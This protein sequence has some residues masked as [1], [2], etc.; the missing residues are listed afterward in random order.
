MISL[1][2][3][4]LWT[5]SAVLALFAVVT[6]AGLL[7]ANRERS[8]QAQQERMRGL[9]YTLL[10]AANLAPDGS[11]ELAGELLAE[12]GFRQPDSGL[13]GMVTA[14]GGRVLWV[15][16]SLLDPPPA[17]AVPAVDEWRF[18]AA[19]SADD[20]FVLSYGVR[21]L[22]EDDSVQRFG[23]VVTE[24]AAPHFAANAAFVRQLWLWLAIPMVGLLL[25]QVAVLN[26]ALRPLRR[27]EEELAELETGRETRLGDAYP[28][29]LQPLKEALN[30]LLAAEGARRQRYSDALGDLSHSLKTPLAAAR[31]QLAREPVDRA[32]LTANLE[33]MARI[34]RF[35][36][37]RTTM[38][39][40]VLQARRPLAPVLE[41]L[42]DTLRRVHGEKA[43]DIALSVP[44]GCMAR[45]DE[46]ALFDSLGNLMDNACKW[47]RQQVRVTATCDDAEIRVV[48]EDDGP[49]FPDAGLATWLERGAR[50]DLQREG[51]GL[52]L[53]VSRDIL[54]TAGGDLR[55]G[56]ARGGGARVEVLLPT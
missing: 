41:R 17:P 9:I 53:A 46:D 55:L 8:L 18:A 33:Q 51:Q 23:F 4:L 3:R 30:A 24:Q 12:P 19:R 44:S 1:R 48:I 31:A 40:A 47:A 45:M 13:G 10:G 11:L 36:L 50:A 26:L 56:R 25:A 16:P 35:Q 34:I 6:A 42:R 7:E 28:R 37:R 2:V 49:G 52:G 54:V 15:S 38:P 14:P 22:G 43:V 5:A 32:A 29:E 20:R 27:M 39:A 21:W